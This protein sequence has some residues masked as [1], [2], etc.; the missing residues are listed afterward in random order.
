MSKYDT[1]ATTKG[2]S[3]FYCISL[4]LFCIHK[5]TAI[6]HLCSLYIMLNIILLRLFCMIRW[7]VTVATQ[8]TTNAAPTVW[9]I[10]TYLSYLNLFYT[11]THF[12]L[13]LSQ[14]KK[15]TFYNNLITITMKSNWYCFRQVKHHDL[16]VTIY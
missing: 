2:A 1:S 4:I 7:T 6:L 11:F 16:H 14:T 13:V 12:L 10:Q 8:S 5:H 3:H 15:I 9:Q